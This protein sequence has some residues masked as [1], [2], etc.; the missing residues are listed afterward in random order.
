MSRL[1]FFSVSWLILQMYSQSLTA[2]TWIDIELG[3]VATGYNDVRIP[4]SRGTFVSLSDELNSDPRFF[5]RLS[6]GYRFN[7]RNEVLVLYAPLTF[8]YSGQLDKDVFFSGVNYPSGSSIEARYTFNSYRATYRYYL[9]DGKDFQLALGGTLKVRDALIRFKGSDLQSE[10]TDLGVVPLI[11]LRAFWTPLPRLGLLLDADAL[12]VRQGRAEDILLAL[13][14]RANQRLHIKAGYRLLEGG[15][16]NASVYT[17][18]L[19]HY[20]LAGA[21]FVF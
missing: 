9:I 14:F 2:Q 18:S 17:F 5:L 3:A 11:N 1:T 8:V 10:R 15:A 13:T 21:V 7:Q 12:G 20:A 4:G 19:F 6:G 16:D